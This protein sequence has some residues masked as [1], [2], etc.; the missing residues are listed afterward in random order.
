MKKSKTPPVM[1]RIYTYEDIHTELIQQAH[2]HSNGIL[3][4]HAN[5]CLKIG[6]EHFRKLEEDRKN[7]ILP[8]GSKGT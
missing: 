1:L 6:F 2:K 4:E 3:Y 8:A 5:K 7:E